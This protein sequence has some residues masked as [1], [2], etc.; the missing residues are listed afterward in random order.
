MSRAWRKIA[1][2]TILVL[3]SVAGIMPVA[4]WATGT[5]GFVDDWLGTRTDYDAGY[6]TSQK[7]GYMTGG[8]F[9][10]RWP[11][12]TD[13]LVT[14]RAPSFKAGC[15]G[16]D[17]FWGSMSFLNGKY[18]MDKLKAILQNAQA[19]AFEMALDV[20]CSKCAQIMGKFES[21]IDALNGLQ[22]NSCNAA[23][24]LVGKNSQFS[25]A[26]KS[27]MQ[28]TVLEGG[29]NSLYTEV[30]GKLNSAG[31]NAVSAIGSVN[32]MLGG[33]P[34]DKNDVSRAGCNATVQKLFPTK[35]D[36]PPNS[37]LSA[38]AADSGL[39]P[40]HI[41][42]IR[43][44]VGDI[45][46]KSAAEGY[47]IE[48]IPGCSDNKSIPVDAWMQGGVWTKELDAN[49]VPKV[50]AKSNMAN[51]RDWVQAKTSTIA[52]SMKNKTPIDSSTPAGADAIAF[53]KTVPIGISYAVRA[54]VAT[55]T[56]STMLP[57]LNDVSAQMYLGSMVTTLNQKSASALNLLYKIKLAQVKAGG[58]PRAITDGSTVNAG[59]QNDAKTKRC[60][61]GSSEESLTAV[62]H[63]FNDE[64]RIVFDKIQAD[65]E[66]Y[67][68]DIEST[69]TFNSRIKELS[70]QLMTRMTR[71]FG[72]SLANRY[73]RI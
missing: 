27:E 28:D 7:R 66:F 68:K 48:Y 55:G 17:A 56:E 21:I 31:D 39:S 29:F 34:T 1:A 69:D 46:F 11:S 8:G 52:D 4:V 42:L 54:A 19:V 33:L 60:S 58:T 30:E 40:T 3:W 20:L 70:D 23:K 59:L 65:N 14:V 45:L 36:Q 67:K 22:L 5:S 35:S 72:T 50:C 49:G 38:L 41:P 15:G 62:I 37:M 25:Q 47:V 26:I 13:T 6:D 57:K 43:G 10:V 18:L 64:S 61:I 71:L 9:V 32:E 51:M 44:L 2:V 73:G 63:Q 24:N 53:I 12:T 16:I